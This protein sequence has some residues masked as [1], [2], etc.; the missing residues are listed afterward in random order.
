MCAAII[1]NAVE[2]CKLCH[3]AAVLQW[4]CCAV[5]GTALQGALPWARLRVT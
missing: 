4:R 3:R 2:I 1:C 5:P